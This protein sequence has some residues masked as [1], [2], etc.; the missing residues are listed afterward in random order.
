VWWESDNDVND[1]EDDHSVHKSLAGPLS[2]LVELVSRQGGV[3]KI[4]DAYR[5]HGVHNPR[6]LHKEGRAVDVTCDEFPLEK[7]AKLCWSAGFDWVYYEDG[8][9]GAHIH[10]SVKRQRSPATEPQATPE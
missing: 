10:C 1:C 8:P 7:L 4:Q 6:S 9:G 2:N 3:L 5:A